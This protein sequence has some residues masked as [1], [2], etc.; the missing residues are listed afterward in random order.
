MRKTLKIL[1]TVGSCGMVGALAGALILMALAP[2]ESQR[3]YVDMRVSVAALSDYILLPSL[4]IVLVS[5]L[6][7]MAAHTPYL[8]KGWVLVKAAFGIIMF[9]G[10]LHIVGAQ[11]H[12][13]EQLVIEA[14][15][16][17]TLSPDRMQGAL[18]YEGGML[19]TMLILS[20][21]N[22]V[23]GVWRPRFSKTT[24]SSTSVRKAASAAPA[25]K[26]APRDTD[27][28]PQAAE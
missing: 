11:S 23:I 22:I 28:L 1:H 21:L 9:K 12:Y 13:A 5:G 16:G 14:N 25:R 27:D 4:G 3:A 26:A 18:A 6:L 8:S 17:V 20:I 15:G 24:R 2:Q 10:V 19:W 7:A